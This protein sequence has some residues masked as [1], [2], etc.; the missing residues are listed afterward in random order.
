MDNEVVF[1]WKRVK[2]YL[3]MYWWIIAV[4]FIL[5]L[6]MMIIGIK[7]N[8]SANQ[9]DESITVHKTIYLLSL[10][11]NPGT[12][13]TASVIGDY[14]TVLNTKEFS[15]EI[16]SKLQTEEI[17]QKKELFKITAARIDNS[18]CFTIDIEMDSKDDAKKAAEIVAETLKNSLEMYQDKVEI[19][20]IDENINKL[21]S[22]TDTTFML[23]DLMVFIGMI[24]LGIII[25]YVILI[26]DKRVASADELLYLIKSEDITIL[27]KKTDCLKVKAILD[28]EQDNKIAIIMGKQ[29]EQII[30]DISNTS[31]ELVSIV[32]IEKLLEQKSTKAVY[33]A[34]KSLKVSRAEIEKVKEIMTIKK[35]PLKKVFF[36]ES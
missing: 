36:I 27:R 34:V 10:E 31:V 2:V 17:K 7:N 13:S 25:L 6:I 8:M 23:K 11:E 20:N 30:N 5:G 15:Q 19:Y 26:L 24:I 12:L 28:D 21:S 22:D 16:E 32:E 3:K 18:N 35:I 14:L 9:I 4:T 1:S 33:L 29:T